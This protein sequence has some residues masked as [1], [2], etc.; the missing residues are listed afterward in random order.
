MEELRI[1]HL[2]LLSKDKDNAPQVADEPC[3]DTLIPTVRCDQNVWNLGQKSLQGELFQVSGQGVLV[4]V[5]DLISHRCIHFYL[6]V[7]IAHGFVI[8]VLNAAFD[9][10]ENQGLAPADEPFARR[11]SRLNLCHH[12][13]TD[14]SDLL[15]LVGGR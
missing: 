10:A 6:L 12:L 15:L 5:H 2:V 1:E 13:C 7:S 3:V 14:L 11:V 8:S 4:D 9:I